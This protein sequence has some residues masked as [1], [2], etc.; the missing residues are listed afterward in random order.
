MLSGTYV[1]PVDV[2]CESSSRV[3]GSME[4]NGRYVSVLLS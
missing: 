4:L 2:G 3:G 1:V